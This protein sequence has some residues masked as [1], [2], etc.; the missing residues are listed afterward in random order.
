MPLRRLLLSG[1]GERQAIVCWTCGA[2]LHQKPMA[3]VA[4]GLQVWLIMMA[5]LAPLALAPNLLT[6]A[7]AVALYAVVA[8]IAPW[9]G[10][11]YRLALDEGVLPEARLLTGDTAGKSPATEP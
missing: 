2:R 10:Y 8:K 6:M 5:P 7:L 11:R 4:E 3:T 1:A 9:E